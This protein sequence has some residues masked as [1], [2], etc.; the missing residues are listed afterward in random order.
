MPKQRTVSKDEVA[1]ELNLSAQSKKDPKPTI[2]A[3]AGR[4]L[5]P[6]AATAVN[7]GAAAIAP[8]AAVP[9]LEQGAP[10]RQ[11]VPPAGLRQAGGE[12]QLFESG[13]AIPGFSTFKSFF[14]E[15]YGLDRDDVVLRELK[16][17]SKVIAGTILGRI[18]TT[19]DKP[20]RTCGSRSARPAAAPR[21]STPSRSST[22][23]S[24][25]SRPRSTAPPASNP[26]VGPDAKT[27][28]IGQILLMSKE[29]LQRRVLRQP[30]HRD[31]RV[32]PPRHPRRASST[33]ACSRRSSSSPRAA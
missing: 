23:G 26:F 2:A 29:E 3:S 12:E 24:C 31:L 22:A 6:T 10:V 32:R 17:G 15:I 25:S 9:A 4:Q 27:A 33:A 5:A 19:D 13:A 1:D 8:S 20:R 28:T 14:T 18:G 30:E 21:A 11:P 16:V 7:R